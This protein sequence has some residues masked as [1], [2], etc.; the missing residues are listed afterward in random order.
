MTGQ[1]FL[2]N[3]PQRLLTELGPGERTVLDVDTTVAGQTFQLQQINVSTERERGLEMW[4][5]LVDGTERLGVLRLQLDL[6]HRRS[7]R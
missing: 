5:P 6:R 4:L 1:I 7:P 3:R 2:V